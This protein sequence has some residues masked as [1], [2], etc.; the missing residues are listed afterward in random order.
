MGTERLSGEEIG[1]AVF[2]IVL[3]AL[4]MVAVWVI[5]ATFGRSP[6]QGSAAEIPAPR[7]PTSSAPSTRPW[8]A[9]RRRRLIYLRGPWNMG[10]FV[11]SLISTVL[12]VLA[13]VATLGAGL[14]AAQAV[15]WGIP[16]AQLAVELN[17]DVFR[18]TRTGPSWSRRRCG[19]S[20]SC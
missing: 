19:R 5:P 18:I 12:V 7:L 10:G 13:I 2:F 20:G 9:R 8:Y 15:Y 17:R 1:A 3:G 6:M 14:K 16:D 4:T 11:F